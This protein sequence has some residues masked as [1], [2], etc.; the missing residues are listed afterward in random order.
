MN[1][2][3]RYQKY[4]S[5]IPEFIFKYLNL[6]IMNRLKDISVLCG[7]D[8]ASKDIYQ[9]KYYLS[10]F[11]HSLNVA[12]IT[13]RLTYDKTRTLAALFHDISTPVF[14]H[15]IDY[16]NGDYI[17]QE[18]T[19]HKTKDVLYSSRELLDYL[20]ED[21]VDINDI[22]NFK[23]YPVV[24]TPR[25]GLCADRLDNLIGTGMSWAK[26][27]GYEDARNIIDNIY[28]DKIN[29]E[30][31]LY[32]LYIGDLLIRIN[33]HIN[34]LTHTNEDT[35]MM[36]LLADIV[37]LLISEGIITYNDLYTLTEPRVLNIIEN[38]LSNYELRDMY[39]TWKN[40][41]RVDM[42]VDMSIKELTLNPLVLGERIK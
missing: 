22:I 38:N 15:V 33:N 31:A 17:K 25:P 36:M 24:D 28:Y 18:S 34:S 2:Y 39:E 20:K 13:W 14:S 1:E 35:Y 30:I 40:I 42:N 16:M 7:M 10:R 9:F 21:N 8:Y 26:C 29:D 41:D 27:I 5:E 19:E 4:I 12:L 3:L 37:K 11:D 6:N 32:S 23:N